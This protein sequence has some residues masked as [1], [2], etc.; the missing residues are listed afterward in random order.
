VGEAPR[1]AEPAAGVAHRTVEI[2]VYDKA[3]RAFT[4]REM[5]PTQELGGKKRIYTKLL[6][7]LS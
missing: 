3:L 1:E 4:T 2:T 5:E 7:W 6:E